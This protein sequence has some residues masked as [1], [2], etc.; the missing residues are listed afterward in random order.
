MQIRKPTVLAA[1]A[2]A[3]LTLLLNH[4]PLPAWAGLGVTA[5]WAAAM[6]AGGLL[7]GVRDT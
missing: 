1:I 6:L 2:I 3:S 5:V 4:A 7:L